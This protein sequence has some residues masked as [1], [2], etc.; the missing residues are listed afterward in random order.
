MTHRLSIIDVG[1]GNCALIT[2]EGKNV[3]IDTASRTHLLRFLESVGVFD[4]DLVVI[5]HSDED[6]MGGLLNLLSNSKYSVSKLVINPDAKKKSDL[7]EDV[8]ALVGGAH[9]AGRLQVY[10]AVYSGGENIGWSEVSS[11]LRL[12]VIAPSL[13]MVLGGP[14]LPLPGDKKA[15]TSN[16][17]SIVI[18]AHF[19]NNPVVFFAA[20][21]DEITLSAIQKGGVETEAGFL[22][23]PH[24]GGLTGGGDIADFCEQ[25]LAV[26]KPKMVIFSNGR[27]RHGNPREEILNCIK[28][29]FPGTYIACTQLSKSCCATPVVRNDYVS[30]EYFAGQANDAYCAG[31]I[32]IDMEKLSQLDWQ[33]KT[34]ETFVA[35]L[36]D[37]KC[38]VVGQ[39]ANVIK[40]IR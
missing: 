1:H 29:K 4:I 34:H 33:L 28:S 11:R 35:S 21:M 32:T 39:A 9:H 14:G 40:L 2:T 7:W 17:A 10:P 24:H 13:E 12:E 20:D 18:R 16:A 26:V 3:I 25:V 8:R 19:D 6:H 23:F 37:A 30:D 15:I 5:S 36:A 22:V 38:R 31:N 27:G